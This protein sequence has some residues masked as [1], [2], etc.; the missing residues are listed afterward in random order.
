M[1]RDSTAELIPDTQPGRLLL[2][3][4]HLVFGDALLYEASFL[5]SQVQREPHILLHPLPVAIVLTST[6]GVTLGKSY[7]S[8]GSQFPY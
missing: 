6:N 2:N 3:L 1:C 5:F 8:F 4:L 7:P